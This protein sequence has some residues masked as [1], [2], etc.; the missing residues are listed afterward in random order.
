MIEGLN[1]I[2][3]TNTLLNLFGDMMVL[4]IFLKIADLVSSPVCC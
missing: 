4:T 1:I 3:K 2:L